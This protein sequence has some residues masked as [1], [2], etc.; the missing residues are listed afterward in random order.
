MANSQIAAQIATSPTS[1]VTTQ[2]RFLVV[3]YGEDLKGDSAAGLRVAE[4]VARWQLPSVKAMAVSQLTPELV[5]SM[6]QAD[7]VIFVDVCSQPGRARSF[8]LEPIVIGDRALRTVSSDT[9]SYNLLTLLNLTKQLYGY[10]PLAWLLL[11][12]SESF[13]PGK[14]LSS[15][16]QR[17]CDR[18]LCSIGQFLQTYQQPRMCA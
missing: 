9:H 2:Y 4:T 10:A 18:A 3:G 17:G 5:N 14:A 8:Q 16:S 11:I 15:T 12:P 13:E 1:Q 6:A 7:Y